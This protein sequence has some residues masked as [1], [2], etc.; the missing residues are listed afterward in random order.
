MVRGAQAFG[1]ALRGALNWIYP[2]RCLVCG[3]RGAVLCERCRSQVSPLR[4]G[5]LRC[6]RPMTTP[7]RCGRCLRREPPFDRA[8]SAFPYEGAVRE[9]ILSLKYGGHYELGPVLGRMMAQCVGPEEAELV[10]PVPLHPQRLARRGFNQ[11]V[12]LATA[13]A[14]RWGIP[15]ARGLLRK[16]RDTPPQ[17]ALGVARR[18]QNPR[19]AFEVVRPER[20]RGRGVALVDDVFTT[21]ATL[22]ECARVLKRAGARRVEALTLARTM[23]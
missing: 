16:R 5:C 7:G 11:S 19:G 13:A 6:G 3:A 21:G 14:R 12:L 18:R 4:A 17:V 22:E 20:V 15:V 1:G 23:G 10:V 2:Q 9:A 8:R